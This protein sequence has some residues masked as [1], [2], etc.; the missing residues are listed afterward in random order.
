MN[1]DE[2]LIARIRSLSRPIDP[3][4]T[5]ATP[6]LKPMAG[7]K[8]ILFDVYGTLLVSA[9]GDIGTTSDSADN[10]PLLEQVRLDH[11]RR[12]AAGVEFPEVEIRN[13]WKAIRPGAQDIERLAV[14]HECRVN[15]VWPMPG[16]VETLAALEQRGLA[17]GLVSNA[18]FYTPLVFRALLGRPPPEP[19]VWSFEHGEAKP[20]TR[21]IRIALDALAARGIRPSDILYIGND[22]VK[23]IAPAAG[24]GCRTALFAGDRRSYRPGP[25]PPDVVITH[26][27]QLITIL[28]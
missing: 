20:S 15:P 12:H 26:L 9:S 16:A 25:P 6:L 19:A 3:I 13:I 2:E 17:I 24:L 1:R 22:S 5:G 21:L 4:P 27:S 14:E 11:A 10:G 18:Q 7:V 28:S 23:D 8:A